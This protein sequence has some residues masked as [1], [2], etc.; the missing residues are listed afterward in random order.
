MENNKQS[1]TIHNSN[2]I[3]RLEW[4]FICLYMNRNQMNYELPKQDAYP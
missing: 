1:H 4:T 2:K 3:V